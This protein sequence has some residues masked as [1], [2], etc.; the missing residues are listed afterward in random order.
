MLLKPNKMFQKFL[1]EAYIKSGL[2]G[3]GPGGYP[4]GRGHS[5]TASKK[6]PKGSQVILNQN[7]SF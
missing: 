6:F 5:R 1:E 7:K 4:E 3:R 2:I